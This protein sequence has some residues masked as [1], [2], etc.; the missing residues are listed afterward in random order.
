MP[1]LN[2]VYE[3]DAL[4]FLRGMPDESADVVVTSP[5]YNMRTLHNGAHPRSRS[6]RWN[7]SQL[8]TEGF[9]QHDDAMPHAE[10]VQWQRDVL[11]ELVR[12][13]PADGAIFYNHKYRIQGGLLVGHDDIMKGFPVRQI[14]IWDRMSSPNQ[15]DSFFMPT[16]EVVYLIC[17][18][19]FRVVPSRPRLSDVWRIKP[20]AKSDHPA[21]FPYELA[22]RCII[23]TTAKIV[24]DPFAGSGTTLVAARDLG[25]QYIG[26]DNAPSYVEMAR[27]RL[28]KP[29]GLPLWS[30][31]EM[32]QPEV[33]A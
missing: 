2:S 3:A 21:P 29:Y 18:P 4:A 10:Y 26:C 27:A 28:A 11:T 6:S 15:N 9:E 25:R 33:T 17:K 1:Q 32:A 7:C 30:E 19:K 23:S 8:L 24:L 16:Y 5:P 12:L 14:I 31:D 22:R 20:E 13:I